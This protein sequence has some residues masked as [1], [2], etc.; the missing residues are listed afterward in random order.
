MVIHQ[1][2]WSNNYPIAGKFG[3]HYNFIWES[4]KK[5]HLVSFNFGDIARDPL[6]QQTKCYTIL[7]FCLKFAKLPN[8]KVSRYTVHGQTSGILVK[9]LHCQTSE[10]LV[11][12]LHCQTSG[13][14][15][16]QLHCQTSGILVKQLHCQTSGILLVKQLH[17]QTSG[18]LTMKES[19]CCLST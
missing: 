10:I 4:V 18:I 13:I 3:K 19:Y 16:K 6:T 1:E 14:L 17:C 9:Q 12:Q 11:K 15:V 2:S 5:T 7:A 8:L